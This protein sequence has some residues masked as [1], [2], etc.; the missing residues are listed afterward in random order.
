MQ[1]RNKIKPELAQEQ[2][3]FVEEKGTIKAM[4]IL[5]TIIERALDVQRDAY[6]CFLDH[7]TAFHRGRHDEIITQ[8]TVEDKWNRPTSNKKTCT[9]NRQQQCE[10]IGKSAQFKKKKA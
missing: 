7:I 4:Y 9:E 5:R 3:G 1:F 6:F 2:G 10:V 8:L